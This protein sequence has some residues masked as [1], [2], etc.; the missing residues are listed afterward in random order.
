M[1][2]THHTQDISE[3]PTTRDG[4]LICAH[5]HRK[6]KYYCIMHDEPCCD[7]CH[8]RTHN[9]CVDVLTL[10]CIHNV[11]SSA[12]FSELEDEI[13]NLTFNINSNEENKKS[14]LNNLFREKI[15]VLQEIDKNRAICNNK[16]DQI[17]T[18]LQNELEQV[19][20]TMREE[21][22]GELD[23]IQYLRHLAANS[24]TTKDEIK[25]TSNDAQCFLN[26]KRL[27]KAIRQAHFK[28]E[29]LS[30]VS[31]LHDVNL[32]FSPNIELL[33][34]LDSLGTISLD[35][36][37][38]PMSIEKFHMKQAQT[39]SHHMETLFSKASPT[40][41]EKSSHFLRRTLDAIH[42]KS[43]PFNTKT[44]KA[45]SECD[46]NIFMDRANRRL[47]LYDKNGRCNGC[48]NLAVKP[49]EVHIINEKKLLV[50]HGN[51]PKKLTVNLDALKSSKF[52][53]S[54]RFQ[55]G[56]IIAI[57]LSLVLYIGLYNENYVAIF[58]Q[59]GMFLSI[60]I[61]LFYFD[62]DLSHL[63]KSFR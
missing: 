43:E 25:T 59:S 49:D 38:K 45:S 16:L 2:F 46:E 24:R 26:M 39:I 58:S 61:V 21:V 62:M 27:S 35:A 37:R 48:L 19:F 10:S 7:R 33:D 53:I 3:M 31:S 32:N 51:P 28:L 40:T 20:N 34:S 60:F 6:F 57:F 36:E 23:E 55:G 42:E 50:I 1:V 8:K 12:A 56:V 4:E 22:E 18:E 29:S 47:I 17:Q 9:K 13:D 30:S 5:H 14:L 52:D 11:Q 63:S 41:C 15:E 54:Y 44:E